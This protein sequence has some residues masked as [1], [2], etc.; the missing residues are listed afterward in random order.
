[1]VGKHLSGA[2][3]NIAD[4][5]GHMARVVNNT[6]GNRTGGMKTNGKEWGEVT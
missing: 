4:F 2:A 6:P 3:A 1:L 5:I